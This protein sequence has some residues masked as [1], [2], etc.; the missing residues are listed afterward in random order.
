MDGHYPEPL[1]LHMGAQRP[2]QCSWGG[3][4]TAGDHG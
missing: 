2:G 1:V 3:D 4:L